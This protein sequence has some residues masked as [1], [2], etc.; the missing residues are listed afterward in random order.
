MHPVRPGRPEAARAI[1]PAA[2]DAPPARPSRRGGLWRGG[3]GIA[4]GSLWFWLGWRHVGLV[5]LVL[6]ML[7]CVG[8]L[9]A[10]DNLRIV[11]GSRL[12]RVQTA[13]GHCVTAVLFAPVFYLILTPYGLLTRRGARDPLRRTFEPG[14]S[15]YWT[16]RPAATRSRTRP[17]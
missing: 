13:V 4:I 8:I 1:W 2:S 14:L 3:V 16:A 17:F 7:A 6:G 11:W 10:S 12:S 15:S 5:A 9:F